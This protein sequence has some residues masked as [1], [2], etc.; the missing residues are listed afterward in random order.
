MRRSLGI[1]LVA[2]IIAFALAVVLFHDLTPAEL[3][4]LRG[5]VPKLSRRRAREEI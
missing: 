5:T 2:G 4:M 3:A 1:S